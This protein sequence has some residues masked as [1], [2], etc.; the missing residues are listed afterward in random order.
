MGRKSLDGF[1]LLSTDHEPRT[2]ARIAAS[3]SSSEGVRADMAV[4][5][6]LRFMEIGVFQDELLTRHEPTP[7]PSEEGSFIWSPCCRFPSWEG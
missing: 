2:G 3:A 6:L 1:Q 5:A 4:R 7:G